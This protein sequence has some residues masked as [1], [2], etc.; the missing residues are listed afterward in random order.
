MRHALAQGQRAVLRRIL[1][2]VQVALSTLPTN[3]HKDNKMNKGTAIVGFIACFLSGM[4]LMYGIGQRPRSGDITPDTSTT[5][6]P[7]AA[8]SDSD[9]PIPVTSQ[10]PTWGNRNAPVTIVVFSDFQCPFCSRVE[11]TLDQ[12]KEQYGKDKVRIVWKN[13]P[14]SFHKDAKPAA[15]AAYA[16]FLAKGNDAFWKFHKAAF[17][18]Q[19]EL[20]DANYEKW[21]V[22]AGVDAA[23]FK[24]FKD[25]PRAAAKVE[26]DHAL[27]QKV[28]VSGTPHFKINGIELSGAQPLE[29]FKEV[30][31]AQLEKAKAKAA[32]GVKPDK[33]YVEL[34]K[35]NF[36]AAPAQDKKQQEAPKRDEDK[37]I[38]KIPVG[39]SPVD[40]PDT[41]MVTIVLFSDFQCP[42]CKRVEDTLKE[43]KKAYGDKVRFVWK[44]QPLPFHPRAK[45]AAVL[46]R[47]AMAQKGPKAFWEAHD[48]LFASAPKLEDA[49][50]ENLA[51]ELGLDVAKFKDALAKD[52]YKDV[53]EADQ[54]LADD[55]NASGTPHFFINGIRLVGAQPLE[56]F[57][58]VIDEQIKK[59]EAIKAKGVP[60][61]KVY[62]E[63]MK[64]GK[65]PPPP[66]M[67]KVPAPGPDQPFKGGKDAKV[68]I[69]EFSDFQCPFCSRV[70]PTVKQVL[71][72]YGN[73]VK[74]VWRHKPLPFHKEAPLASEASIEAFKQKGPDAFWKYHDILFEKQKE[75]NAL[76]R[77]ALESYAEQIGLDMVKFKKALDTN[78]HKPLV[79][80]D[81]KV[82]DD[83]GIS[84]TPAFII[85]VN[86]KP[87]GYFIS[88][89]QPFPK[90]KKIIDRALKEAK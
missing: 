34:S 46:A 51:K 33:I 8:W 72:T 38:W 10:D 62:D 61:N 25:D 37:T 69:Q 42:F 59:A 30:I 41:A 85:T 74:I 11:G 43:V 7:G 28:G 45:P 65:E 77:P 40:G 89:A 19:R 21:A 1:W 36:K 13:E 23:T 73:K 39:T 14:L 80:A 22:E 56:K 18:G 9:S 26:E 83:A 5:T 17:A 48:K 55:M 32:A 44:D 81:S 50:L 15:I 6:A 86:N 79:D 3:K 75:P 76:L 57:K 47:E 16:V 66:E 49:D 63:I 20:N 4:G 71:E 82:A 29:K 70:E 54:N 60:A 87:E 68:V 53:I 90:F 12:I 27:A 64:E 58:E 78:V 67:K 84:G 24:K 52:K 2:I 88:G 31:D 35:E